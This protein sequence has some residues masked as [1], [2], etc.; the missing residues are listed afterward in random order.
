MFLR[1]ALIAAS[2]IATALP[3]WPQQLPAP[4][5]AQAVQ[6]DPAIV[7]LTDTM[8]MT[9]V[10]EVM[11]QEG[12][13]YGKTL[14]SEMFPGQGGD[15]WS[16]VVGLIYDASNMREKFDLS[17]S[18]ELSDAVA[19]AEIQSFFGSDIGHM[20][21]KLEIEARRALLDPAV[22]EAAKAS[23]DEM[24]AE[25]SPR[26]ALIRQFAEVNDLTESNVMGALNANLAFYK[27]MADNSAF[28]QEMT[29]DQMLS[30]VWAQEPDVRAE[31]EDWLFPFLALAYQPMSDEDL[32]AYIAF[33]E[34]PAGQSINAALFAA[35]DDVFTEISREL[36][37][38]VARQIQGEDI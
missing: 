29:E 3:A 4:Q 18:R 11:Q 21:L 27:G 1:P 14:E 12:V 7:A 33:S 19:L 35:F 2:L 13:E 6:P 31:T 32:K 34:T 9:D 23:W 25:D 28:P 30:D 15:R 24:V 10:L 37:R 38:A 20:A 8:M 36:G 17:L 16:E 5:L 26:L 22:E